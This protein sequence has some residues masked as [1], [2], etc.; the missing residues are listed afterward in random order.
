MGDNGRGVTVGNGID[1]MVY[2]GT[3]KVI[4]KETVLPVQL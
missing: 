1:G 2:K 3:M 4:R